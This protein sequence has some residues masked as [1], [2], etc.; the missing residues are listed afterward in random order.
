VHAREL[1]N[2][3][4]GDKTMDLDKTIATLFNIGGG[5]M[6]AHIFLCQILHVF[7]RWKSS[8]ALEL[9]AVRGFFRLLNAKYFLPW[10]PPPA[11]MNNKTFLIRF[12]FWLTRLTGAAMPLVM[13]AFL[14]TEC[15]VALH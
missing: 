8:L 5:L 14:A 13:L 11:D 9:F 10:V 15:Y 6:V 12:I 4:L 2:N 3:E 1:L 7:V